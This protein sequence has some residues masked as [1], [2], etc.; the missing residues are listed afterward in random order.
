MMEPT[1]Q[2]QEGVAAAARAHVAELIS[3]GAEQYRLLDEVAAI[4]AADEAAIRAA[5]GG[6]VDVLVVEELKPVEATRQTLRLLLKAEPAVRGV[7]FEGWRRTVA[8]AA[9]HRAAARAACAGFAGWV[10]GVP[11][12]NLSVLI[13]LLPCLASCHGREI[14]RVAAALR[15]ALTPPA[16]PAGLDAYRTFLQGYAEHVSSEHL[17]GLF[18]LAGLCLNA[19]TAAAV[20]EFGAVCT[21]DAVAQQDDACELLEKAGDAVQAAPAGIR[22]PALRLLTRI[23]TR[24]LGSAA[25]AASRLSRGITAIGPEA[26]VPYLDAFSRMVEHVGA[27]GIGFCL[28]SLR[29]RFA[30]RDAA[31]A[32]AFVDAACCVADLAGPRAAFHFVNRATAAARTAWIGDRARR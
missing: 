26:Q 2:S 32:A 31:G 20:R 22:G 6:I 23:A 11:A 15:T 8:A 28:G 27:A 12:A 21:P 9:P 5:V 16:G 24:S 17:E 18:S 14:G 19:E 30:R 7:L 13:E 25:H 10:E 1:A 4:R 29:E 3:A